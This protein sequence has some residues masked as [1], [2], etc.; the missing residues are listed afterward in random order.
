MLILWLLTLGGNAIAPPTVSI[1]D[2][3][4]QNRVYTGRTITTEGEAIGDLMLRGEYGWVNLSD[5]KSAIGVYAS[6][7]QLQA[8]KN[9][10]RYEIAGDKVR[11]KGTFYDCCPVHSGETDIHAFSVEITRA[12]G[13]VGETLDRH[14]LRLSLEMAFLAALAFALRQFIRGV[15]H[16]AN[17]GRPKQS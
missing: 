8:I 11:V 15:A 6:S 10:G 13:T 2:L 14:R 16:R 4:S 5:G 3:I 9:L 7:R 1:A 17:G 12:G